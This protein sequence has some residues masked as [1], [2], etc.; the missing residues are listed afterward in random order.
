MNKSDLKLQLHTCKLT[1]ANEHLVI[2]LLH[3]HK[4]MLDIGDF[5]YTA[6]QKLAVTTSQLEIFVPLFSADGFV[7]LPHS[8]F[9]PT[10]IGCHFLESMPTA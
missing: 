9:S 8:I 4:I 2:F 5:S 6:M 10:L 7:G 1:S 3:L